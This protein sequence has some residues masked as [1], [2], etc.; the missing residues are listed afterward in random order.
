MHM[1]IPISTSYLTS[2][3]VPTTP[4]ILSRS[5]SRTRLSPTSMPK[6]KS[7]AH[8]QQS[9]R[10]TP[11]TAAPPGSAIDTPMNSTVRPLKSTTALSSKGGKVKRSDSE[12]LLRAGLA[13]AADTREQKGQSWLAQRD[14]STSLV[15]HSSD[16]EDMALG[17][18]KGSG[19]G[20]AKTKS[21]STGPTPVLSRRGSRS[22][23]GGM[24]PDMSFTSAQ[25]HVASATGVPPKDDSTGMY[26]DARELEPDFV[27]GQDSV[28]AADFVD[29]QEEDDADDDETEEVDEIEM[30]R[31]TRERGFGLGG[32]VDKVLG[33]TLFETEGAEEGTDTKPRPSKI[34]GNEGG[35]EGEWQ[36]TYRGGESG[37]EETAKDEKEDVIHDA[38]RP[39]EDYDGEIQVKWQDDVNWLL[40]VAT[41]I[42]L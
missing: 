23:R 17:M 34:A 31:L 21:R 15:S 1:S 24:A 35:E 39:A 12:W 10:L 5:A 33:W 29:A 8:L 30:Q 26:P 3:S 7:H 20:Y 32:L 42:A 36:A 22:G 40:R 16:D 14:S 6:S 41:R 11:G 2:T 37:D 18:G 19:F 38:G 25:D 4:K 13:L 28:L 27:D 9:L